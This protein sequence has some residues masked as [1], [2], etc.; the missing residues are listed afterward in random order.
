MRRIPLD[1]LAKI[2]E[3]APP[4][5]LSRRERLLRWAETLE[6]CPSPYLRPLR[7]VELYAPNE[8]AKLRCDGSPLSVAY[9]DPLLRSEGLDGDR[10][11]DGGGFFGISDRDMHALVCDCRYGGRMRPQ[12]VARRLRGL[13][14]PNPLVRLWTRAWL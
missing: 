2:G 11:G 9:A 1:E 6:R 8:R 10:L 5:P 3:V 4:R 13:G 14:H 7:R 12:D